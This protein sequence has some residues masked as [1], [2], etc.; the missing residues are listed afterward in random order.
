MIGWLLVLSF[1]LG[2]ALT[3]VYM[4]RSVS[5]TLD[6][7]S[8]RAGDDGHDEHVP[9]LDEDVE[10]ERREQGG[11]ARRRTVVPQVVEFEDDE[12]FER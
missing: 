4:V 6:P 10:G 2:F 12:F 9:P 8:R 11:P 7:L 1:V 5:R 3:W